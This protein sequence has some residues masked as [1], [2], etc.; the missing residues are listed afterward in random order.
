M[1]GEDDDSSGSNGSDTSSTGTGGSKEDVGVSHRPV[2]SGL[3][4]AV[5]G[6]VV[7]MMAL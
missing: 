5:F 6:A 4:F 2:L 7:V 1:E 3:A